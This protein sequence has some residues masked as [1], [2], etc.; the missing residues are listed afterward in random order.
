MDQNKTILGLQA[1]YKNGEDI[2]YGYK[3]SSV[4]EGTILHYDLQRPDYLKNITGSFSPDGFIDQ[5][6]FSSKMGKVMKF[7]NHREN[8]EIFNFG[9]SSNERPFVVYGSSTFADSVSY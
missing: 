3:S 9:L 7:G 2:R 4:S 8:N 1:I 6:V 5:L